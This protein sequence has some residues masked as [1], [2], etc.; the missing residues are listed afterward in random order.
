MNADGSPK[1]SY[2]A[3]QNLITIL[4]DKGSAFTAGSLSYSLAG[5]T[6]HVQHTLLAKRNGHYFL[7]LWLNVLEL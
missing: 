6:S 7:A 4:S 2:T 1:Q 3:I 5:D